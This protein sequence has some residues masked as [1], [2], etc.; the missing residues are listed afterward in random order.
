MQTQ[1]DFLKDKETMRIRQ[2]ADRLAEIGQRLDA[3]NGRLSA[4]LATLEKSVDGLLVEVEN[5]GKRLAIADKEA[6]DK[7]DRLDLE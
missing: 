5:A 7:F 2:L 4:P 3:I 1:P 6:K